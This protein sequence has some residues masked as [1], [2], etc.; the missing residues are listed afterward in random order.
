[1]EELNKN[2]YNFL[3]IIIL[4]TYIFLPLWYVVLLWNIP[5]GNSV[6]GSL[7]MENKYY[8]EMGSFLIL[9]VLHIFLAIIGLWRAFISQKNYLIMLH[10]FLGFIS[11]FIGLL[12]FL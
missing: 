1:M 8:S 6:I 11:L 3:H 12:L 10:I 4:V 7:R 2:R 5:S 9:F